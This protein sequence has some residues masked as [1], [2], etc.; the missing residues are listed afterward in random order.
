MAHGAH[1]FVVAMTATLTI[2]QSTSGLV[3]AQFTPSPNYQGPV[4][5]SPVQRPEPLPASPSS[6]SVFAIASV[7]VVLG[8]IVAAG[9]NFHFLTHCEDTNGMQCDNTNDE[10][11]ENADDCSTIHTN[12]DNRNS[13]GTCTSASI[14][15]EANDYDSE[16]ALD[17]A[18]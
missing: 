12:D 9:I 15:L 10:H 7:L 2:L 11:C 4:T 17:T 13:K 14:Q 6:P 1:T 18:L 8:L 16:A 5:P 3:T